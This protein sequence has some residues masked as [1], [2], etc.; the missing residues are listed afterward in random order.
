MIEV[1]IG[2][3]AVVLV[4]LCMLGYFVNKKHTRDMNLRQLHHQNIDVTADHHQHHHHHH[5]SNL[6]IVFHKYLCVTSETF[7]IFFCKIKHK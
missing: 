6:V 4:L 7:L 2:I 3:V 1:V 5:A